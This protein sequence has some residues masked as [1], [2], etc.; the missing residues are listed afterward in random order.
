MRYFLLLIAS[1][2]LMLAVPAAHAQS[3]PVTSTAPVAN[4]YQASV[5]VADTSAASRG[6]AFATA[7]GEVLK[8]LSGQTPDAAIL[9]QAST[10]VQQYQYARAPAG[11]AQPFVLTVGFAPSA[12]AHLQRE[13]LA[14]SDAAGPATASSVAGATDAGSSLVWV[15]GIGSAVDFAQVLAQMRE[16][17]GVTSVAVQQAQGHGMLLQLDTRVALSQVVAALQAGG[18]FAAAPQPHAGAASSLTWTP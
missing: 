15:S 5:P 11:A 3:T 12:I 4:P 14:P 16:L 1:C 10:Y 18:H 8:H 13:M 17:P 6:K 7:L 9:G 2:G